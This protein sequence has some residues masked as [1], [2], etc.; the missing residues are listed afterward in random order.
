MISKIVEVN[1]KRRQFEHPK[2]S[3]VARERPV[4]RELERFAKQRC[5][6]ML[7]ELAIKM[8]RRRDDWPALQL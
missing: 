8:T 7:S 5:E 1:Q 6:L 4:A 3:G 2:R